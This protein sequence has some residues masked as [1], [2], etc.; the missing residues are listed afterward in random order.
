MVYGARI[1]LEVI[2]TTTRALQDEG[3]GGRRYETWTLVENTEDGRVGRGGSYDD[4][5][6]APTFDDD[7]PS[8]F[9]TVTN[10]ANRVRTRKTYEAL[11]PVLAFFPADT[12]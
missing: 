12:R 10:D 9:P 11:S 2:L 7:F 4:G 5:D 6:D 3:K 1:A 8:D